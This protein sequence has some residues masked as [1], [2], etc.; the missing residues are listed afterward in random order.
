[1]VLGMLDLSAAFDT[2]NHG[3]LQRRLSM[4]F[5]IQDSVLQWRRSYLTERSVHFGVDG[6]YSDSITLDC[7]LPQG[8]QIG[9]KRYSDYVMHLGRLPCNLKILYHYYADDAQVGKSC[10]PK[11]E[12]LHFHAIHCLD[13]RIRDVSR[14]MR[15]NRLQINIE[16]KNEFFV[17]VSKQNHKLIRILHLQVDAD[18]IPSVPIT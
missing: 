15:A 1:M 7:S 5:N 16:K 9:P 4:T 10:N 13:D 2:V 3:I 6:V 18:A 11:D 12:D 8:S 14:W 17:F